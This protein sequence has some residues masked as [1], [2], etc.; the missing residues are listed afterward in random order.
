MKKVSLTLN[1]IFFVFFFWYFFIH[2]GIGS[3]ID[4]CIIKKE[5]YLDSIYYKEKVRV[6]EELNKKLNHNIRYDVFIG[7]SII[8]HFPI[9]EMFGKQN[10]LNRGIELDSTVGVLKRLSTII[11][12][13]N[14][15]TCFLLIGYNDLQYRTPEEICR[16]I[17][18]ILSKIKAE[19]KYFI[20]LLPCYDKKLNLRIIQVNKM[21]KSES[22]KWDFE[23]IDVYPLFSEENGKLKGKYF[24]DSV[25]LNIYGYLRLKEVLTSYSK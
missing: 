5:K 9:E 2:I 10:V 22:Q 24:Y 14:I 21:M 1:V 11:N 3:Y 23:C 6:Y 12:N 15:S 4:K 20:S 18:L 25:H 8:E 7:D 13:I 19:K 17:L 16:N